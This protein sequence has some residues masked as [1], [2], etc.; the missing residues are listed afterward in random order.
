MKYLLLLGIAFS[1]NAMANMDFSY[2]DEITLANEAINAPTLNI[3]GSYQVPA[4][5]PAKRKLTPSEKMKM[6]RAK[7]ELRNKIMMEKKMEQIRMKQEIAL[8]KQL[9]LQMNKTL[10]AINNIN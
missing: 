4:A 8:A 3:E 7:L 2:E 9:E 5:A 10:N 1:V 6:R